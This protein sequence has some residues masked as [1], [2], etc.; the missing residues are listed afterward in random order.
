MSIIVR[1]PIRD[2]IDDLDGVQRKMEEAGIPIIRRGL[3]KH[4]MDYATDECVVEYIP[5]EDVYQVGPPA[6]APP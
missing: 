4:T 6:D 5:E 1:I 2:F 3:I